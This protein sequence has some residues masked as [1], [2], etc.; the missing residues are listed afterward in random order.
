MEK[1]ITIPARI[2][3]NILYANIYFRVIYMK[4]A[5]IAD[6]KKVKAILKIGN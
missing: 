1:Y 5:E 3:K 2:T 6:T 4:D